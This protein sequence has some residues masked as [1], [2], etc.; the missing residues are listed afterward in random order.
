M[1][2]QAARSGSAVQCGSSK[3]AVLAAR[4]LPAGMLAQPPPPHPLTAHVRGACRGPARLLGLRGV[5]AVQ[6]D[7]DGGGARD[8]RGQL[9]RV[10]VGHLGGEAGVIDGLR[11]GAREGDEGCEWS[12]RARGMQGG[13]QSRAGSRRTCARAAAAQASTRR[14]RASRRARAAALPALQKTME[15]A[16]GREAAQL[17]CGGRQPHSCVW[18]RRLPGA[19]VLA[20][21]LENAMRR[22]AAGGLTS[23][24]PSQPHASVRGL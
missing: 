19:P 18:E 12:E 14:A 22:L 2:T 20:H 24:S 13:S 10:A 4:R 5:D 23:C 9:Q 15:A 7:R 11:A 21:D 8:G 1:G 3:P 6:A 16:G 17:G